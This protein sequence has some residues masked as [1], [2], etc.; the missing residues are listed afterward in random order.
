MSL[1]SIASGCLTFVFH[2]DGSVQY[3]GWEANISCIFPCQDF[4][5]NVTN[6]SEAF[7]NADTIQLCQNTPLTI[8]VGGDYTNNNTNYLQSDATSTFHWMFGDGTDTIGV[9][10]TTMTHNFNEGGSIV[11]VEVTDN[12][13][14]SNLN[15]CRIVVMTSVTP[16]FNGTLITD[17]ICPGEAVNFNGTVNINSWEQEIPEITG[18]DAFID[19]V[20]GQEFTSTITN[21]FFPTG[22]T[23]TNTTNIQ[24]ICMN[25]EHSYM[26]D[27][28]I[29]ITCPNGQSMH[30]IEYSNSGGGTFLG[31]PIASDLPVDGNT[32]DLTQGIGYDY[33]FSA[34]ATN[35]QI[36]DSNN[37]TPLTSYTDGIGQTST[38]TLNQLP[39]GTY[40]PEGNWSDLVGCPLNGDWTLHFEDHMGSDNGYIFSWIVNWDPVLTSNLWTYTN[41]YDPSIYTWTGQNINSQTNGIGTAI[42][43]SS[44]GDEIYTFIATDDFGCVYDTSVSV[45]VHPSN[46]PGCCITP[47]PSAGANDSVC[48]FSIQFN[49]IYFD[50]NNTGVWTVNGP[51]NITFDDATLNTATATANIYGEYTFTWTEL[52]AAGCQASDVVTVKYNPNPDISIIMDSTQCFG[53]SDGALTVIHNTVTDAPYVYLWDNNN[54]T[55]NNTNIA[56]GNYSVAVANVHGCFSII[57]EDV[58][59]STQLT[60]T[61]NT[62]AVLCFNG[63][64]GSASVIANNATPGYTYL[65]NDANAQTTA[66]ATNLSSGTYLVTITDANGCNITES[67]NVNQPNNS[68]SSTTLNTNALCFGSADG[69]G[70]ISVTGGTLPY[71]YAWSNTQNTASINGLVAN[72]YNILVTDANNC[73]INDSITITE[74]TEITS[75]YTSTSLGCAESNNG[76][77]NLS[78]TGGTPAYSYLWNT[79]ANTQT[80]QDIGG[81]VY[82]VTITDNNLCTYIHSSIVIT[83][84]D[85][86][87][88]SVTQETTICL[89]SSTEIL[90]SALGGN[91]PY[92]YAW[93]TGSTG[94]SINVAPTDTTTYSII[95]TDANGCSSQITLSTVNVRKA[96]TATAFSDKIEVCPG[97]PVQVNV[98]AEGGNNNYYYTL[99]NGQIVT[100]SFTIYPNESNSY[101]ITVRDD[102]GSPTAVA[103][104]DIDVLPPPSLSFIADITQGC[105]PLAVSFTELSD[106]DGQTFNWDFGDNNSSN[107]G[108]E[109]QPIHLYENDGNYN[110]SLEVTSIDGCKSTQHMNNL[111]TVYKNPYSK[112]SANNNNASVIK[113]EIIFN[114]MSVGATNY[115]WDFGDGNTYIGTESIHTYPNYSNNYTVTLVAES[116]QGCSDTSYSLVYINDISTLYAPTAFTPDGDGINDEWNIVGTG[117]DLD[118]VRINIYNR[119]GELIFETKNLE[120]GWNGIA[121]DN[122][123]AAIGSYYWLIIY[124]DT[125]GV[126][127]EKSGTV[128]IIK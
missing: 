42:P 36:D 30:F 72:T 19:D 37:W 70:E 12:N 21:N 89:T 44:G 24:D 8:T 111:I 62:T 32:T 10:L 18:I 81:D 60:A 16:D 4:N 84:P 68:L 48:G 1:Q 67:V 94:T 99:E 113:P 82:S 14:C 65:W 95:V 17:T 103:K 88:A 75:S 39:A 116:S 98:N 45:Y 23:V 126:E 69:T 40:E 80:I 5:A 122:K 108:S 54:T 118:Y 83:E 11:I 9:G 97:D 104:I 115:Y 20:Q 61:T 74:P 13:N 87:I 49:A 105:Q 58:E 41:T 91:S 59:Q 35:G 121:K 71:I 55:I 110:V 107:M 52:N 127:Y 3:E 128:T 56:S 96:I 124:K 57:D 123:P 53:S 86:V 78:V 6:T 101:F 109:K 85:P 93:N 27:L 79:G 29:W 46:H 73:T 34:T 25:M 47:T 76:N 33:C 92:T 38:G 22:S 63:T 90:C 28:E 43:T 50:A 15:S 120:K 77:I 100:N 51:G 26:G 66:S 2:S 31:E 119:W 112:F 102:C 64:D 125:N 106:D 117:I 7:Y 114:N